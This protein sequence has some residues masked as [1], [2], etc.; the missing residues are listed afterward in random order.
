MGWSGELN[1][2]RP[3]SVVLADADGS[4]RALA[5][6]ALRRAGF[7]TIEVDTG[8]DALNAARAQGVGAVLLEVVL[9]EMTGYEVCRMLR[10]EVGDE[11]AIFF[12]AGTRTGPADRVA[13]LLLGADDFIVKPFHPDEL[14]VR[15]GRFVTSRSTATPSAEPDR[16]V[17]ITARE[18][19]VLTLLAA[20]TNQKE[21]ARQLTISSKTVGT[22]IQSLLLKF[23]VHSRAEL[24]AGAYR[25]G[26]VSPSHDGRVGTQTS[27]NGHGIVAVPS[28]VA[29]V[30]AK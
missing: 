29:Y 10:E 8:V 3:G 13:G 15:V 24:V 11:L 26:F 5:A 27:S 7:E 23:G 6:D 12:L 20:G 25:E 18:R 21:I 19:E 16:R 28:E 30:Q 14:V 4:E 17:R 9:P 1:E 22:H 2:M